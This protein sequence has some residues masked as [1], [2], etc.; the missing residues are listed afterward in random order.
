M[1][2]GKSGEWMVSPAASVCVSCNHRRAVLPRAAR[3]N[4]PNAHK[5]F[6]QIETWTPIFSTDA[7]LRFA[8]N[9]TWSLFV[10]SRENKLRIQNVLLFLN[11][12]M[13][14]IC[15]LYENV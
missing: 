12:K 8:L 9:L 1:Y 6:Q 15:Q 14:G 10:W 2:R 7:R 13:G 5:Q 4:V 3:T 11:R